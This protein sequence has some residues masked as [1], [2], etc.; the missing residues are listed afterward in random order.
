MVT[1]DIVSRVNSLTRGDRA[2]A[3]CLRRKHEELRSVPGV[4]KLG[5]VNIPAWTQKGLMNTLPTE[6]GATHRRKTVRSRQG[7]SSPSLDHALG[8]VYK[9]AGPVLNGLFRKKRAQ[10]WEGREGKVEL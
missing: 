10:N 9:R 5:T 3:K 7:C 1:L 8:R 6:E 2:S 4:H